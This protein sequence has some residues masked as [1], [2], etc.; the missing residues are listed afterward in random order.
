VFSY[1]LS[2]CWCC[3][4]LGWLLPASRERERETVLQSLTSSSSPRLRLNTL[5]GSGSWNRPHSR[6]HT[7]RSPST[8]R[9]SLDAPEVAS[10]LCPAQCVL[11]T[12]LPVP[13]PANYRAQLYFM[14]VL[15]LWCLNQ[16]A[17]DCLLS[18][19][20]F[21][22]FPALMEMSTESYC[23]FFSTRAVRRKLVIEF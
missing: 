23:S 17:R 10:S 3:R 4:G 11:S 14:Q 8:N 2:A 9:N 15:P 16:S 6:R 12:V 20:Q 19:P 22:T 1:K 5:L 7:R 21:L 13:Q 18:P